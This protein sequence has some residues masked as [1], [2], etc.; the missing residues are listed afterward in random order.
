MTGS[1]SAAPA[2]GAR[3]ESFLSTVAYYSGVE[4]QELAKEIEFQG[5][6]IESALQEL[7]NYPATGNAREYSN[8]RRLGETLVKDI[9]GLKARLETNKATLTAETDELN[10]FLWGVCKIAQLAVGLF[11]S[12]FY[13]Y[14]EATIARSQRVDPSSSTSH[15][16]KIRFDVTQTPEIKVG[17][18]Q[19][20]GA[21][22]S[23]YLSP[24]YKSLNG[25]CSLEGISLEVRNQAGGC[26]GMIKMEKER[27]DGLF[28]SDLFCIF[29]DDEKRERPVMRKLTQLIAEVLK[30]EKKEYVRCSS[31]YDQLPVLLTGG[32]GPPQDERLIYSADPS[33]PQQEKRAA[34]QAE[35]VRVQPSLLDCERLIEEVRLARQNGQRFPGYYD[36]GRQS[37]HYLYNLPIRI[38]QQPI[39]FGEG[40]PKTWGEM[41]AQEPILSETESLFER[42]TPLS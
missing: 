21:A 11:F 32:F 38:D 4:H 14:E 33:V 7:A 29:E 16:R 42:F 26:L 1:G 20:E 41:F 34:Q 37:R 35:A 23:V 17:G 25:R 18:F 30:I 3:D 36:L 5:R 39:F 40:T 9:Q 28:I 8:R 15:L 19:L 12:L 24:S 6:A 22:A 13:G 10:W 31:I 2:R 27:N